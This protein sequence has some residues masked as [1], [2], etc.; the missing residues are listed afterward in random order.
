MQSIKT[1]R[2]NVKQPRLEQHRQK[3]QYGQQLY[4]QQLQQ[5][6]V[7]NSKGTASLGK[8]VVGGCMGAVPLRAV[9]R[10]ARSLYE[11]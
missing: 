1:V 4:R 10:Q 7:D 5:H 9:G 8:R 6:D 3:Q 2:K 11:R